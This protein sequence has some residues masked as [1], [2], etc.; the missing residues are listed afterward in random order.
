[1][2]IPARILRAQA[3]QLDPTLAD[4]TPREAAQ[5]DRI[6]EFGQSLMAQ[7]GPHRLNLT[8]FATAIKMAS[9]TI[10]KHFPDL[11][12]LLGELC[13]RHLARIAL[14]IAEVPPNAPQ[15]RRHAAYLAA[16]RD[17]AG[18]LTEMHH[19]FTCFHATLPP[20]ELEPVLAM[21]L[22]IG[23]TLAPGHA[24]AMLTV[25]DNPGFTAAD[26]EVVH[27]ALTAPPPPL[28]P[29]P[30]TVVFPRPNPA[31]LPQAPP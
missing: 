30:A 9:W 10:K 28:R 8:R 18:R 20:D 7:N 2:L 31:P 4:L 12:A 26:I 29:I 19:L 6:L 14:A 25:L 21:H 17:Q 3:L 15:R 13:R 16:T 1:M 24:H 22:A 11:H 23:E 27:G 5:R